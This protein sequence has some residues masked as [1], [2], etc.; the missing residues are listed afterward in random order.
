[1]AFSNFCEVFVAHFVDD[2]DPRRRF[3]RVARFIV[4]EI[5]L[6]GAE[7]RY[8]ADDAYENLREALKP[9]LEQEGLWCIAPAF[10]GGVS[11]DDTEFLLDEFANYVDDP[12]GY[13]AP[14]L[15]AEAEAEAEAEEA[16]A[17]DAQ[18]AG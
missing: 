16:E 3:E 4:Q 8:T 5:T 11:N 13:E 12:E 10:F 18:A 1:M 15:E 7:D 17:D 9:V 14:D 2:T 6:A